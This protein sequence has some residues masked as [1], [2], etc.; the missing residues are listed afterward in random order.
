MPDPETLELIALIVI[1]LVVLLLVLARISD[2]ITDRRKAVDPV[3]RRREHASAARQAT[4]VCLVCVGLLVVSLFLGRILLGA[5]A[6]TGLVVFG[7]LA[8]VRSRLSR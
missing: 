7:T 6:I 2:R 8:V 5:M 3:V 4:T 1:G